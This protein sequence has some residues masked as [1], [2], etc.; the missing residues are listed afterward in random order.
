MIW[1]CVGTDI[2]T[3]GCR[4]KGFSDMDRKDGENP[5]DSLGNIY[6]MLAFCQPPGII[7]S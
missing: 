4:R 3:K 1:R 7:P 5:S 2:G 6:G